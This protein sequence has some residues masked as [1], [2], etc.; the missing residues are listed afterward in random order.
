[1]KHVY[2]ILIILALLSL[3]SCAGKTEN[4]GNTAW[5]SGEASEREMPTPVAPQKNFFFG[6][7]SK[8]TDKAVYVGENSK[9]V[10]FRTDGQI[11]SANK[12]SGKVKNLAV[13][14][15]PHTSQ[16][17]YV[18]A[19]YGDMLYY[20][21][22]GAIRQYDIIS[23][24]DR[25]IAAELDKLP[26]SVSHIDAREN[27]IV[28]SDGYG[29]FIIFNLDTN[30]TF[31]PLEIDE[32]PKEYMCFS[33]SVWW[34]ADTDDNTYSFRI[35]YPADGTFS[36]F[37]SKTRIVRIDEANGAL[38]YMEHHGKNKTLYRLNGKKSEKVYDFSD[39]WGDNDVTLSVLCSGGSSIWIGAYDN[40]KS[41]ELIKFSV[42]KN[43]ITASYDI[44]E[45]NLWIMSDRL[46][47]NRVINGKLTVYVASDGTTT[48]DDYFLDTEEG[49]LIP[50]E[51]L[52]EIVGINN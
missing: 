38:Y 37:T 24:L 31:A 33:D 10:I 28:L 52:N 13:T 4:A 35:F 40:E 9:F 16:G 42:K 8:D 11:S 41:V 50:Y 5:S 18:A 17:H 29:Q 26:K 30:E 7:S 32:Y 3:A 1:M 22:K 34:Y 15:T 48:T 2:V 12:S 51:K 46:G 36:E 47:L 39:K 23:G 27:Y 49:K 21:S 14:D 43:K 20:I 25:E 19:F 6:D 45:Q 44:S